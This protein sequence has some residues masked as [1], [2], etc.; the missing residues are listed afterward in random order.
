MPTAT[1][2]AHH[3]DRTRPSAFLPRVKE[4]TIDRFVVKVR[5][6]YYLK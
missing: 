3:A 5:I 6:F 2:N 4:K 1:G